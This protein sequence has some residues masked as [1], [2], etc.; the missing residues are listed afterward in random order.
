M[1]KTKDK[2][3]KIQELLPHLKKGYIAMDKDKVNWIQ[4]LCF[5]EFSNGIKQC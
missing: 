4:I 5:K 1:D 3:M 2:K